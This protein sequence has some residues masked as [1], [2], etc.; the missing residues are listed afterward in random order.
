MFL[1][2]T[3]AKGKLSEIQPSK[4][5]IK[6]DK[7]FKKMNFEGKKFKSSTKLINFSFPV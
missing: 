1:Q 6:L 5:N 7:L 2:R 4:E 3:I